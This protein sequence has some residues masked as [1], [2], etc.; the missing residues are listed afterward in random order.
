MRP[1]DRTSLK[2][3]EDACAPGQFAVFTEVE[4]EI[5]QSQYKQVRFHFVRRLVVGL[6]GWDY[7]RR[8][9]RNEKF[10]GISFGCVAPFTGGV[11]SL[12]LSV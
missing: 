5:T 4:I 12:E 2:A 10:G 11:E 9:S 8:A 3:G 1:G 6:E 7:L